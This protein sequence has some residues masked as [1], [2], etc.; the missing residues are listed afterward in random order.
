MKVRKQLATT[1]LLGAFA[2]SLVAEIPVVDASGA[3][4]EP[5]VGLATT[6]RPGD[7]LQ[8]TADPAG[9]LY[10]LELLR[11]EVQEL[12]GLVEDQAHR[13]ERLRDEQKDRYL[14]LDRRLTRLT[15]R[16]SLPAGAVADLDVGT[17][18]A[19]SANNDSGG[20]GGQAEEQVAYQAAFDLIRNKRYDEAV[21]ALSQFI[22]DYPRGEY[23]ANAYY[24]LGEVQVVKAN[25]QEA[26]TA[27]GTLL[28]Q[29]SQ[30]RKVPDAKYK[31]GKVYAELGDQAKA[32]KLL[33]EVVSQYPK[34]SAA[35]LAE[36]E[37]RALAP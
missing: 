23:V 9:L 15:E 5:A 20:D 3:E 14:D 13:L 27:F 4:R 19:A 29:F 12:R 35:K 26:L 32:Q 28:E 34:S 1:L 37:L 18:G 36:A 2:P 7:R 33:K 31:L 8:G 21:T 16:G 30:H 22:D 25:Y 24:W 10:Q 6:G 17:S 11:V